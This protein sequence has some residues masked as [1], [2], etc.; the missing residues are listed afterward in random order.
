MQHD[1]YEVRQRLAQIPPGYTEVEGTRSFCRPIDA[2]VE[3]ELA[4]FEK[5]I[6]IAE[7][8]ALVIGHQRRT[9]LTS[10]PGPHVFFPAARCGNLIDRF[11]ADFA[12]TCRD[13]RFELGPVVKGE[14][15]D[16]GRW[17]VVLGTRGGRP[18]V[19]SGVEIVE[20]L[21][22]AESRGFTRDELVTAFGSGPA[23]ELVRS[24]AADRVRAHVK[25]LSGRALVNFYRTAAECDLI[26][27]FSSEDV[28]SMAETVFEEEFKA[29]VAGLELL[30]LLELI[31]ELVR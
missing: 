7:P 6:R 11:D 9:V 15:L 19:L 25:T 31:D 3:V 16:E 28:G 8:G 12:M 18:R 17:H 26:P 4:T 13:G 1:T 2:M 24:T 29:A 22:E 10:D 30:D 27:G 5:P 14:A 21:A 20:A 23:L